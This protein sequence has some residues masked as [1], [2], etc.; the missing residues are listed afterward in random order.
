MMAEN[1]QL[2]EK[3]PGRPLAMHPQK[4]ALWLFIVTV[5]MIFAAMTS[6]HIVRQADGNW[7]EYEMPQMLIVSTVIIVV[8]S[9]FLH[10]GYISAKR[11][12]LGNLKI[13]MTLSVITGLAFFGT[14]YTAWGQLVDAGVYFVG[15]P[16][17]SF[18]Y[19]ITG[20]HGLHL[21]SG[22]IY[23]I[24]ILISSLRYKVHSKNMLNM[25]M[26]TTYWHFLGGLWI[27]LYIFLL[28]NH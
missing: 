5:M 7:L 9:I 14:Q 4:F 3:Q 16:A 17:G 2:V 24:Y 27:Y 15:N 23:L 20:L 6:A 25:E 18:M 21:V 11:D 26:C 19:V 1:Y 28:L 12:N 10:W 8:S 13:A 22:V